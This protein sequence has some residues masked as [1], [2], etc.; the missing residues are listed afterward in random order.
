MTT[1]TSM[2]FWF[3]IMLHIAPEVSTEYMLRAYLQLAQ[4]SDYCP[5]DRIMAGEWNLSK[6]AMHLRASSN[7]YRE[8]TALLR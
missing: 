8:V 7:L 4:T 1:A 3:N 5:R 6:T 2:V